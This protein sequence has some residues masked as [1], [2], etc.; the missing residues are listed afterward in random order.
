M[1]IVWKAWKNKAAG[2]PMQNGDNLFHDAIRLII[3]VGCI[4]YRGDSFFLDE[5]KI[6]D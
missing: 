3:P 2:V 1:G 5:R 4:A 6:V